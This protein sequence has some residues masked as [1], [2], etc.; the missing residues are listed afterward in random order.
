MTEDRDP[1][2]F[3]IEVHSS[4]IDRFTVPQ[5]HVLIIQRTGKEITNHMFSELRRTRS[6]LKRPLRIDALD[7]M[8]HKSMDL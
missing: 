3:D 2:A 5:R 6:H 7:D 8:V 4:H 1:V